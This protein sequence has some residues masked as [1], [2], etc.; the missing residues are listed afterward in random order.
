MHIMNCINPN[1]SNCKC[2]SSLLCSSQRKNLY[3]YPVICTR[4][5]KD[6]IFT[7]MSWDSERLTC[8]NGYIEQF[9]LC[10]LFCL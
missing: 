2:S 8:S 7:L 10:M 1:E 5:G 4:E 3:M 9:L 6:M